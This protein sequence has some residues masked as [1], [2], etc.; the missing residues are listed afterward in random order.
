MRTFAA[1]A[2]MPGFLASWHQRL[3]AAC[4][5]PSSSL[6][7]QDSTHLLHCNPGQSCNLLKAKNAPDRKER[8]SGIF[9]VFLH[10]EVKLGLVQVGR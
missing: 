5:P 4:P 8:L 6:P 3:P 1:P 2:R 9:Y 7:P 10:V